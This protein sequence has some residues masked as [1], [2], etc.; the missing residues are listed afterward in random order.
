MNLLIKYK[1]DRHL[2]EHARHFPRC[3]FIMEEDVGNI[4]IG[5][6]PIR[7]PKRSIVHDACDN[8]VARHNIAAKISRDIISPTKCRSSK[9]S[10]DILSPDI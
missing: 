3:P 10:R 6:D 1:G 4:P 2:A 5:Q 8:L 7:G 9:I